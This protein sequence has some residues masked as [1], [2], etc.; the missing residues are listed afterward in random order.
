MDLLPP[1]RTW[2]ISM[3]QNMAATTYR[4]PLQIAGKCDIQKHLINP[5]NTT[6]L[7]SDTLVSRAQPPAFGWADIILEQTYEYWNRYRCT[8]ANC[9]IMQSIRYGYKL[10]MKYMS[11]TARYKLC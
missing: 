3:P 1:F 7:K 4:L 11:D 8:K 2:R 9:L 10:I 5:D 6:T